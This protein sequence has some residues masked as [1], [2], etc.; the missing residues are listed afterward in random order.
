MTARRWRHPV[1]NTRSEA[2]PLRPSV[3][4]TECHEPGRR[5][6]THTLHSPSTQRQHL[7]QSGKVTKLI[8]KKMIFTHHLSNTIR[9]MYSKT[10]RYTRNTFIKIPIIKK[11]SQ[12]VDRHEERRWLDGQFTESEMSSNTNGHT[13]SLWVRDPVRRIYTLCEKRPECYQIYAWP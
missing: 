8:F 10:S 4:V 1:T 5:R 2:A 3:L 7:T 13:H 9:Y 6:A 11:Q 12:N